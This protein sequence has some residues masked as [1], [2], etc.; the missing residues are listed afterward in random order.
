TVKNAL[1]KTPLPLAQ[2][3]Y[4]APSSLKAAESLSEYD[5]KMILFDKMDKT[6]SYLTH[7]KH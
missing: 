7:D 1:D 2:S 4:Q 5:L 6:R 3:S